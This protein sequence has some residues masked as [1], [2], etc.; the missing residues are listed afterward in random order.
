M[1]LDFLNDK[2]EQKINYIQMFYL[3]RY[4]SANCIDIDML[5]FI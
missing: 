5:A 3:G 1:Y 4:L 2:M